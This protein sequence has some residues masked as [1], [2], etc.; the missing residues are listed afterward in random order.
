MTA[1]PHQG[2]LPGARWDPHRYEDFGDHRLRPGLD[3]LDRVTVRQPAVI[4]DLGCGT[5]R[6]TR[7]LARRWPAATVL[8]VDASADM[9]AAAKGEAGAIRW[10]EADLRTWEPTGP[11]DLVFSNAA[12]HWLPD[13]ANLL[14]RL[15]GWLR[16]GGCLAVQMPLSWDQ[17][18]HRLMRET[19]ADAGPD[20]G[21]LGPETLR[22]AMSRRPVAAPAAYHDLLAARTQQLD[23]WETEYLHGL[24][25]EDPVLAW[26]RTT[27]LRPVL[28]GLDP[29]ARERFL[30]VYRSR[31]R[32]AYP[33]RADG[34]TLFPFRRLFLVATV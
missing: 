6:L 11:A 28:G 10:V 15:L 7:R 17:P 14:P 5:G 27:G 9:L 22:L 12:L 26:V 24:R 31:L 13:H 21:P 25:G 4:V 29:G 2:D 34:T 23:I 33:T 18:S 8:G 1:E 30:A 19:L 3:L 16:P 32:A 20:G